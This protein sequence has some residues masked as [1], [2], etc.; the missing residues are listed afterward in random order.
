M[1][2]EGLFEHPH[3]TGPTHNAEIGKKHL[4]ASHYS[5]YSTQKQ[6]TSRESDFYFQISQDKF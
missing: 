4:S 2:I 5:I 1:K 6:E 3:G